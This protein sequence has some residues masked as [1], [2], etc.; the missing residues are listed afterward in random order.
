MTFKA[1]ENR[2]LFLYNDYLFMPFTISP[3]SDSQPHIH[4]QRLGK[5]VACLMETMRVS[6]E[7]NGYL[8]MPSPLLN[9]LYIFYLVVNLEL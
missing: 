8:L 9:L 7:V 5:S 1:T 3:A 4:T 2:F 6:C